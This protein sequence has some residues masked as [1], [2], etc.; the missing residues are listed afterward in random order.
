[1]V[2]RRCVVGLSRCVVGLV[3][4]HS[5]GGCLP[6]VHFFFFADKMHHQVRPDVGG[7]WAFN[8]NNPI[9]AHTV[10][11]GDSFDLFRIFPPPGSPE[12][13]KQLQ[14]NMYFYDI[15]VPFFCHWEG[16]TIAILRE[17]EWLIQ[18]SNIGRK[19]SKEGIWWNR[20]NSNNDSNKII[21]VKRKYLFS[22]SD[23]MS[24]LPLLW[25]TRTLYISSAGQRCH[26][27]A[28]G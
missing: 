18:K 9:S 12:K 8:L 21:R 6:W 23:F 11:C 25:G 7:C 27:Y 5:P 26:Q 4:G 2:S 16:A 13:K 17:Q 28:P 14:V 3:A 19:H 10:D 1:M 20:S 24:L 22:L 15:H